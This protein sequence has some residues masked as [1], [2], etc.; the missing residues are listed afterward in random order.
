MEVFTFSPSANRES[1]AG[2]NARV[3]E[4]CMDN[5]VVEIKPEVFRNNLVLRCLLAD[6]R[7]APAGTPT[8]LPQVM[9]IDA[10]TI[11]LEEQLNKQIEDVADIDEEDD[12]FPADI[13]VL[14][15]EKD[16]GFSVV[17]CV[18]GVTEDDYE[19]VGEAEGTGDEVAEG[20]QGDDHE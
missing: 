12:Y 9:L 2:F 20:F 18:N 5:P 15:G 1:I 17:V 10:K 6:D 19:D 3:Q 14:A 8:L 4:Y 7:D 16:V 13:W 11:D